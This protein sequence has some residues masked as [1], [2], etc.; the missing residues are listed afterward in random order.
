MRVWETSAR[1]EFS[2]ELTMSDA[3][4]D[5]EGWWSLFR[6]G[7]DGAMTLIGTC[8]SKD[9]PVV[10]GAIAVSRDLL[11]S[12]GWGTQ[13]FRWLVVGVNP[14]KANMGLQENLT[15]QGANLT[16]TDGE[17]NK[18]PGP[19]VSITDSLAFNTE[20]AFQFFVEFPNA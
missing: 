16:P 19:P 3:N 1:A 8:G 9:G 12:W 20:T 11:D 13:T 2:A 5:A 18:L 4:D 7:P 15:S 14:T 17:G 6:L 10:T